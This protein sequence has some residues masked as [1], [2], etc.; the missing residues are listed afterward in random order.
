MVVVLGLLANIKVFGVLPAHR[1]FV[2]DAG[3]VLVSVS[4]SI[5]AGFVHR[6]VRGVRQYTR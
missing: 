2:L 6:E 3:A 1:P 5:C 4:P